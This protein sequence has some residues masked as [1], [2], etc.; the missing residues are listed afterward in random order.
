MRSGDFEVFPPSQERNGW[1]YGQSNTR[2][3]IVLGLSAR[4]SVLMIVLVSLPGIA[5]GS[6]FIG[7]RTPSFAVDGIAVHHGREGL[8][9]TPFD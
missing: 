4:L 7:E 9:D 5:V 3:W 6:P 1:L 2:G 8:H